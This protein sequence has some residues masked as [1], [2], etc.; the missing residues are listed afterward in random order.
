[1][2]KLWCIHLKPV[3]HLLELTIISKLPLTDRSVS[4]NTGEGHSN[5]SVSEQGKTSLLHNK[6]QQ[7]SCLF[8]NVQK[9]R[10]FVIP[11]IIFL[12]ECP[13][14]FEYAVCTAFIC[15]LVCDSVG[16]FFSC[17]LRHYQLS[18]FFTSLKIGPSLL[19][20]G[21]W[22]NFCFSFIFPIVKWSI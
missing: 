8:P 20:N 2:Q 16:V 18:R 17:D 10:G 12:C 22:L 15:H 1:M 19:W 7:W 14:A 5:R 4:I 13:S 3:I 6:I 21:G 11:A 9:Q